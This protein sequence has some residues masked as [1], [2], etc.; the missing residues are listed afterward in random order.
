MPD[1]R[2]RELVVVAPLIVLLIF[3]GVYPKPVTDIVNPAVKQTLSDVHKKD[4]KPEV[5]A[6]K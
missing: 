4:P 6:A 2:A 3:L 1:L 5:E